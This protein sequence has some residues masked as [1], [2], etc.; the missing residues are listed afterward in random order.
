MDSITGVIGLVI[1]FGLV[2]A[3]VI[4]RINYGLAL[5]L[6]AILLG[7]FFGSDISNLLLTAYRTL[8]DPVTIELALAV[9]LIPIL[10]QSLIDTKLVDG[11][12]E[13]LKTRLPPKAILAMI[14]AVF[15]LFPMYGGAL[16]SAPLIDGEANKF[17]VNP[18]RKTMINLWFRHMWF[19]V[20]PLV[21][22]L[23]ILS[24]MTNVSIYDIILVNIPV[25][26]TH[27]S[28]GY[29][30]LLQPIKTK[31][32]VSRGTNSTLL[33][34]SKGV[35]PIALAIL[36][37]VFGLPL[38]LS[39]TCGIVS[40]FLLGRICLSE[41]FRTVKKGFMMNLVLAVLGAMY[42]RYIVSSAAVDDFIISNAEA[43]GV[44]FIAFFTFIPLIFGFITADPQT[45]A[46]M[47]AS[48]VVNGQNILTPVLVS[49]LYLSS[50][51]SYFLSPLHLCL[52]LTVGYFR[53]K[54]KQ[55]YKMLI[56]MTLIDYL[57]CLFVSFV[58]LG[59]II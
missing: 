18:T 35:I 27:T 33:S 42:F 31:V 41:A 52:I 28:V 50:F 55:V 6:G 25:F 45:S 3:L 29:Y 1:S 51:L 13:G 48:L 58:L 11:L 14:P 9:M 8:T 5:T 40:A 36:L 10:A 37:N 49:L 38:P 2:M 34:L 32:L 46:I 30:F 23:I 4:K 26:L 19:F 17:D 57:I 21:S 20:S 22:I 16:V 39:L 43:Y 56:P 53:S 12:I 54:L 7:L 44:P 15:G 24:K 47:S 59:S